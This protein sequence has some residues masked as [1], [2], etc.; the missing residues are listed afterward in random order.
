MSSAPPPRFFGLL[1]LGLLAACASY[2]ALIFCSSSWAEARALDEVFP[3]YGG[4]IRLF[5][6]AAWQAARWSLGGAAGLLTG[7]GAGCL[8]SSPPSRQELSALAYETQLTWRELRASLT[9]LTARQRGLALA[10]LAALTGLRLYFS[11]VTPEYDDEISYE[12][13][14]SK[15]LLAISA[16]YPIPNNHVL[17]NTLDWLFFRLH[18]G[19]WWTM[20]LPV[21]LTSTTATGLWFAGLLRRGGFRVA[22]VATTLFG[23]M[24]LSLYHAA[25]GRGYWLLTGLAGAVFFASLALTAPPG[26]HRAAWLALLLAGVLG[27]YTVPT[28]AYVLASAFSWL[29]WSFWRRQQ[30]ARLGQLAAVAVL[31][32]LGAAMLYA[33]LLFVSGFAKLTGNHFVLPLSAGEFWQSLPAYLWFTEGFLAGQRTVGAGLVLLGLGLVGYLFRLAQ[34]GQLPTIS[35]HR[36]RRLGRPALWFMGVPYAVLLVQRVQPPERVLFYKA[37]FF[38]ILVGLVVDWALARWPAS[39]QRWLRPA[40]LAS[41]GLFA[42][43]EV[44]GIVRDNRPVRRH[45]AAYRASWQW[46]LHQPPGPVL[47]P[48]TTLNLFF[49]FYAHSELPHRPEQIDYAPHA[50]TRYAY[51]VAF[52]N[53]RGFF[54]PRFPF[55]PT[56]RNQE[57]AI[58]RVPPNYS[59]DNIQP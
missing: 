2:A 27:A 55:L 37:F 6:P 8:I 28:F 13:F 26:R 7:V 59:L 48:E 45:N 43:Y 29:G 56:F 16:Y 17:S 21:L 52:A 11:L 44:T 33:P 53:G 9:V 25:V 18:P 42:S 1:S 58:Y 57:V 20:R 15:G 31:T 47:I 50:G 41:A 36:L 46:L 14:V 4:P 5:S 38:F 35:A 23:L 32:G 49:R 10:T 54:H 34:R 3:F 24:Q 30:L 12:V 40:L 22:A 51:V 39:A 19:F